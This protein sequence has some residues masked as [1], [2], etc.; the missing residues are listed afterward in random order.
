MVKG[1]RYA[2]TASHNACRKT[3]HQPRLLI[4]SLAMN[5]FARAGGSVIVKFP[6]ERVGKKGNSTTGG[7]KQEKK[8]KKKTKN[9]KKGARGIMR[10]RKQMGRNKTKKRTGVEK[11]S[12][13]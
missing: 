3:A 2:K 11:W 12:I 1:R 4:D 5:R 10:E 7:R 13:E 8:K 6:P 9:L